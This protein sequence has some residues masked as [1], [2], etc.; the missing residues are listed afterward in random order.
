MTFSM[1]HDV[2][3]LLPFHMDDTRQVND[4]FARWRQSKADKD[5]RL[6]DIWTYC[7]IYRYFLIKMGGGA[8]SA[9]LAFD[10]LVA[11]AFAD[12]QSNLHT[13]RHPG[14]YAG[15][16]STICR[17]TFVNHLRTQRSMVSLEDGLFQLTVPGTGG[18]EGRDAAVLYRSIAGAIDALP[19]FLRDV[20]RMRLLENRSYQAIQG[21]TGKPLA[22]LRTYVNKALEHLRQNPTLQALLE[23]MRDD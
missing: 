19:D 10:R 1:L 4:L 18:T 5:K 8:A 23:E 6:I 15:W 17:H 7:Y 12:V 21:S 3:G 2:A 9:L 14:C 11:A 20:A 13:I 22:T 16:I